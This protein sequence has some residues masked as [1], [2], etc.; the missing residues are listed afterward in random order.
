MALTVAAARVR[1]TLAALVCVAG[2]AACA[3][4]GEHAAPTTSTGAPPTSSAVTSTTFPF[5]GSPRPSA[6]TLAKAHGLFAAFVLR[7]ERAGLD[8]SWIAGDPVPLY[9]KVD[10]A[11]LTKRVER[12]DA[13]KTRAARVDAVVASLESLGY[14]V[15]RAKK[16]DL[17]VVARLEGD[18]CPER[19]IEIVASVPDGAAGADALTSAAVLVEVAR[20][21]KDRHLP[22]TVEFALIGGEKSARALVT[23]R[24]KTAPDPS[25]AF[26]LEGLGV[27]ND[28]TDHRI[29]V[30]NRYVLFVADRS[31]EFPARV[32]S[33]AAERF[34]P[35]FWAWVFQPTEPTLSDFAQ[36][37]E[38]V[39][40]DAGLPTLAVTDSGALR[41]ERVGTK[42]DTVE[43]LDA[44]FLA[45]NARAVLTGV[46][47]LATVDADGDGKPDVCTR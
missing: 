33:V 20:A 36:G 42:K 35:D 27:A 41:D 29:G 39:F 22:V 44:D 3:S 34:R 45:N 38:N 5:P 10:P 18:A 26:V 6:E 16:S 24:A 21:L 4:T 17:P 13:A 23:D 32:V 14:E 47:G 11:A 28:A 43:R 31:S 37:L 8:P 30:E 19:S 40:W 7:P 25:A 1:T 46:V 15:Q 2:L 9:T 12:L